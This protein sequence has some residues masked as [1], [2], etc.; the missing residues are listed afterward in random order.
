[1]ARL[2][3]YTAGNWK[4]VDYSTV[5]SSL[6]ASYA[7]TASYALSSSYA[8][9]SSV[10]L[11]A[12]YATTAGTASYASSSLSSSFPWQS[13]GSASI[14]LQRI[15]V[16]INAPRSA[17]NNNFI[18]SAGNNAALELNA[19]NLTD[20]GAF[21]IYTPLSTDI[22]TGKAFAFVAGSEA[23]ARGIFYSDGAYGIGDGVGSRDIYLGRSSA[24]VIS[25]TSD[26]VSGRASLM[27]SNITASRIT[28]STLYVSDN[29]DVIGPSYPVMRGTR[30]TTDTD[31][32]RGV[33]VLRHQT[34]SDMVD[35]FGAQFAFQIRDS[36]GVDNTLGGFSAVRDGADNSGK[37]TFQVFNAGVQN[38]ASMVI[39]KN[40]NVGIGIGTTSP[41]TRLHVNGPISASS[42][43]SGSLFG[44]ASYAN[45][46]LSSSYALTA[47]YAL[48]GGSGGG[49]TK[50]I[51]SFRANDNQPI[52]GSTYAV[53]DTRNSRTVIAYADS[54]YRDAIFPSVIP[55]GADLSS[56]V[57]V[58][59]GWT[60][61]TATG[62]N[63]VWGC[64]WESEVTNCDTSSYDTAVETTSSANATSGILSI[65]RIVTTY[66]DGLAP[67]TGSRLLIYRTGSVAADTMVGTAQ[68]HWVCVNQI[69]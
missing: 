3:I 27:V 57:E 58:L 38:T 60:G 46:A 69:A 42:F 6:S 8:G 62:S 59:I 31:G 37:L 34:T 41:Q 47:S 43:G 66:L 30:L 5:S 18:Y 53:W 29:L 23:A 56:G 22:N 65:A 9:T 25:I 11:Q 64:Q 1:M 55:E 67:F 44:T 54:A 48:N 36:A 49:G 16:G 10:A 15:G 21:V 19:P 26:K 13:N 24:G 63:V 12:I 7:E 39:D 45:N 35:G 51:Q 50:T 61:A 32:L 14:C 20:Q 33:A 28:A 17:L 68:L 40:G 52:S 2:K 4:Y